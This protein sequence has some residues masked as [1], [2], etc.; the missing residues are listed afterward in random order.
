MAVLGQSY[1]RSLR[2][3]H[4]ELRSVHIFISTFQ[5]IDPQA[6]KNVTRR[7]S[8]HTG[9]QGSYLPT[10][11]TN[12][13]RVETTLAR[14]KIEV[15]NLRRLCSIVS[16]LALGFLTTAAYSQETASIVG[17]VTDP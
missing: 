4:S 5:A 11:T 14:G 8:L 9:W 15:R 7:N 13:V 6:L 12:S 16:L 2:N 3:I 10:S 17:T 1:H